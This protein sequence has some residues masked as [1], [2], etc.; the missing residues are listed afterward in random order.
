MR[1][2][3]LG[4]ERISTSSLASA[5]CAF[6]SHIAT[7]CSRTF[8]NGSLVVVV[9][10]HWYMAIIFDCRILQWHLRKWELSFVNGSLEVVLNN[11]ADRPYFQDLC[12]FRKR[13]WYAQKGDFDPT[14]LLTKWWYF[15]LQILDY[16]FADPIII[17]LFANIWVFLWCHFV[18]YQIIIFI[19]I[20]SFLCWPNN[21]LSVCQYLI[22]SLL[23]K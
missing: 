11:H 22:V 13:N 3:I 23:T 19:D 8:V 9:N 4:E 7:Y 20:G 2:L 5:S 17:F 18:N 14:L 6:S 16:F 15:C 12:L 1:K 10:N 21:N